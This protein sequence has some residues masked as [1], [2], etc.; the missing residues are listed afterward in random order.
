MRC[1]G[2]AKHAGHEG[3]ELGAGGNDYIQGDL[4]VVSGWQESDLGWGECLSLLSLRDSRIPFGSC[5][6][7]LEPHKRHERNRR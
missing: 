2:I 4:A 5:L 7:T 1:E 6:L 3:V